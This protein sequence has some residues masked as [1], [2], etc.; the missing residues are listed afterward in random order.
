[1]EVQHNGTWGT[2][3]DDDWDM[4]DA[5]VVCRQLGC[6]SAIAVAS[7]SAFGQGVGPILLDNVDCAGHEKDLGQCGSLGW[8]IHN[9]YHYED[10]AVTC[11][12]TG[13]GSRAHRRAPEHPSNKHPYFFA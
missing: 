13:M 7:S 9:C 12:G 1:M 11:R 8:G 6:G 10:V 3:C 4:V 2:V 5:N